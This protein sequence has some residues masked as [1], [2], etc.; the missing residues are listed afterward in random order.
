[1]RRTPV[2]TPRM[3]D[4]LDPLDGSD[5]DERHMK[6]MGAELEPAIACLSYAL[7]SISLSLFNKLIF[8]GSS[9]NFPISV[10]AFQSLCAVVFLLLSDWLKLSEPSPLTKDVLRAMAPVTILFCLMLWTS[11]K[12]LRFVSMPI[13]TVF[14][15]LAVV[16]TTAW[17]YFRFGSRVSM[18]IMLSLALMV[19]G[20]LAAGA[21]DLTATREGF[22]WMFVN[23]FFTVSY[24]ASLKDLVPPDLPAS[25]KTL[26]NNLLSLGAFAGVAAFNGE[27]GDFWSALLA[28]T[29]LFKLALL[30]TG[31]IGTAINMSTFWCARV[32]SGATYAFVGASNKIPVALIGHF[33]F[34]SELTVGGW[35]G[36][37]MGLGAGIVFAITKERERRQA[38]AA[39]SA[40]GG[41]GD[42]AEEDYTPL[43]RK[44]G[45]AGAG[46]VP[47]DELESDGAQALVARNGRGS[48]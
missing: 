36:V 21:G 20:S 28:Q 48:E 47:D 33:A 12:A 23:V 4:S 3:G 32:T 15:N 42:A 24:V 1:M 29:R 16:G 8:S 14:K 2:G 34:H 45:A 25:A 17:E 38:V 43:L 40:S 22:I 19:G 6:R 46:A 44:E 5:L 31:V 11:G 35:T 41:G 27:I 30:C 39:R 7:C 18:G 13:F 26:A 37:T 9:F 10:L